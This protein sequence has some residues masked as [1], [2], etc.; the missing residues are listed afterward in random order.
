MRAL[1]VLVALAMGCSDV[2]LASEDA[3]CLEA[4]H[5]GYADGYVC[6]EHGNGLPDGAKGM[7]AHCYDDG[8]DWAYG[9]GC[10]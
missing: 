8:Y 9:Q 3:V 5:V 6:L 1:M 2:P 7:S 10:E 4:Y